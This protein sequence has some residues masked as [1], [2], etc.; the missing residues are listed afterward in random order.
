MHKQ[1]YDKK[2]LNISIMQLHNLKQIL[3]LHAASNYSRSATKL[4]M[5]R[6]LIL[7]RFAVGSKNV[8]LSKSQEP[9]FITTYLFIC[10]L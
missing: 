3:A 10:C 4:T 1:Q 6:I 7:S 9:I 8:A 2:H 5:P